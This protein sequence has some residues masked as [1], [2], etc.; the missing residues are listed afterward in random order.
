MCAV[1]FLILL[2]VPVQGDEPDDELQVP[3]NLDEETLELLDPFFRRSLWY[4]ENYFVERDRADS[5]K[6]SAT[7]WRETAQARLEIVDQVQKAMQGMET[8][9]K[10]IV[11]ALIVAGLLLGAKT[12]IEI[13][14]GA[15]Q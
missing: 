5:W 13:I 2:S 10:V 8:I 14:R 11:T 12:V 15:T 4:Y 3:D 9:Q 1:G 6:E 7:G